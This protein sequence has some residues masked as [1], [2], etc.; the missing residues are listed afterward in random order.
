MR[1]YRRGWKDKSGIW[2][3]HS[4][5]DMEADFKDS[6]GTWGDFFWSWFICTL[7]FSPL[8][9]LIDLIARFLIRSW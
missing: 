3:W 6:V 7:V 2:H 1:C 8:F 9:W 4:K 5:E